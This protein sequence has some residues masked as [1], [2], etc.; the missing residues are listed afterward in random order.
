MI[1]R[2]LIIPPRPDVLIELQSL[3][4]EENPSIDH[5]SQ[6]VKK[7]VA[8]YSILLST[9]NSPWLN[10]SKPVQS[11]EQA[12]M[13]LGIKKVFMLVQAVLVRQSFESCNL[14]ESFWTA[15]TEMAGICSDLATQYTHLNTDNAYT[16]GMMHNVGVPVMMTQ[17]EGYDGFLT[18]HGHKS[19]TTLFVE[20]KKLY[21]TDHFF[22]GAQLA[23]QWRLGS[24]V[25]TA[26]RCQPIAELVFSGKKEVP[27]SVATLLAILTLARS[28]SSE[29][30][31]YWHVKLDDKDLIRSVDSALR[32][33]HISE[34]EYTELKED[35]VEDMLASEA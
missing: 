31:H 30:R 19:P 11:I 1:E 18:Q 24:E 21:E 10:L 5:I 35:I 22:Q 6:L 34:V 25:A 2:A 8:L 9:V 32:Y 29:Y 3:M 28:I 4:A 27:H 12:V 33:L 17:F 7:D 23:K 16:L 14:M 13:L 26:I 20:E 15:A